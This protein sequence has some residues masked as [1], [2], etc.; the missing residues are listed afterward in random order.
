MA[1]EAVNAG[2]MGVREASRNFNVPA[3]TLSRRLKSGDFKKKKLGPSCLL[4]IENENKLKMHIKK[5]QTFGFSPNQDSVRSMAFNLAEQ[6]NIKNT[7]NK[8]KRLAGYDWLKMFLSRHPELRFRKSDGD[9]LTRSQRTNIAAVASYFTLLEKTLEENN[10]FNKPGHLFN[11]DDLVLQ[12]NNRPGNV[13][14][15]KGS[16]VATSVASTEKG[17]TITLISCCNAEGYYLPPACIF[18][19]INIKLEWEDDMPP[20]SVVYMNEK[21][22]YISTNL[23]F[24]WLKTHFLPHKPIGKVILILD[25]HSTHCNSV[26]MLEFADK[27]DIILL[28]LPSNTTQHL[29]P[30]DRGF[31][32]SFKSNFNNAYNK[33][34]K[35]NPT[36]I[37]TRLQFGTLLS[38]AW[39]KSTTIQN[40]VSAFRDTG[41]CPFNS[42]IIPEYV[43]RRDEN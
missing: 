7:F 6:L 12:L 8:E 31:F 35:S 21:S 20:G 39:S 41:I 37:I 13:I 43:L 34:L 30:L 2:N 38:D 3:A 29:Q 19:G 25:G 10:L 18:K 1:A 36:Q 4:G 22:A 24:I 33:F 28:C 5:L 23:F 9:L 27:H 40:A 11:V 16:K 17:E 15:Q 32:K 42:N 26:E 14:A